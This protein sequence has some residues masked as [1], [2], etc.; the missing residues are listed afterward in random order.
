MDVLTEKKYM[1]QLPSFADGQS[2]LNA[3][4]SELLLDVTPTKFADWI[5][6]GTNVNAVDTST[7]IGRG[8]DFKSMLLAVKSANGKVSVV[9][10]LGHGYYD[11][12][13]GGRESIH[14]MYNFV[15]TWDKSDVSDSVYQGALLS[16]GHPTNGLTGFLSAGV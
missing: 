10:A 7:G 1:N 2:C 6:G 13:C 15:K 9:V 11:K 8:N 3:H 4:F 14:C 16:R 5:E 12:V